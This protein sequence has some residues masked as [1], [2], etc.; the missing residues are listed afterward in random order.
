MTEAA[1]LPIHDE[2][3]HNRFACSEGGAVAQLQY[4]VRGD[5][6]VLI[7][8][9]VPDELGGRGIGGR[10]VRA[11]IAKAVVDGLVVVPQCSVA[12]KWLREHPDE[13]ASVT[14]DWDVD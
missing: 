9:E 5:R 4:R 11:A 1:I 3:E 6:L 8:T 10:L 2:S 13:A 12:N 14:I 7:H